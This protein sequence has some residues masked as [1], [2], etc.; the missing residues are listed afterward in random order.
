MAETETLRGTVGLLRRRSGP[1]PSLE[2]EL[3]LPDGRR[4]LVSALESSGHPLNE[5]LHIVVSGRVDAQGVLNAESIVAD[6]A[7]V[8][9][10]A[11]GSWW[12]LPPVAAAAVWATAY[13]IQ[14]HE[15][16]RITWVV[17]ALLALAVAQL[18]TVTT[19]VKRLMRGGAVASLAAVWLSNEREGAGPLALFLVLLLAA[20]ISIFVAFIGWLRRRG[21]PAP[22][23]A[24]SATQPPPP[25]G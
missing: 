7:P 1:P 5:G 6:V 4:R 24:T 22:A 19:T 18:R 11:S 2:F 3:R 8:K 14:E 25:P 12:M 20:F 16:S 9:P 13:T 17:L 23:A 21:V 10:P 15:I